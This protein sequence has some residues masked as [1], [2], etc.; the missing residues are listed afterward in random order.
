MPLPITR[1]LLF[2]INSNVRAY[3]V[4][5]CGVLLPSDSKMF[6]EKKTKRKEK[7]KKIRKEEK[8]KAEK[9]NF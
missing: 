6:K 1:V 7:R 9:T 4:R 8:N 3:V 5:R 2:Y